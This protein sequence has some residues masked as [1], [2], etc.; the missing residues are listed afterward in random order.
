[1]SSS[2]E[3]FYMLAALCDFPYKNQDVDKIDLRE[4]LVEALSI[5]AGEVAEKNQGRT[6]GRD[7]MGDH[8]SD[9]SD[10]SQTPHLRWP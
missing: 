7:E 10:T 2:W 6:Q 1:M 3:N 4:S 5:L 8:C 9:I